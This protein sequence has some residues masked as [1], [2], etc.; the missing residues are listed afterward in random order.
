METI[1]EFVR[2]LGNRHTSYAIAAVFIVV[3]WVS[4]RLL[5]IFKEG[6]RAGRIA[7]EPTTERPRRRIP[8]E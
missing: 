5:R 3:W 8:L 1:V 6:G 7:Q 4:S 2:S